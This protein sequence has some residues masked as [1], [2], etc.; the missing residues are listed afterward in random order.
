MIT[1]IVRMRFAP[2]DHA[3]IETIL[4]ELTT[5]SRME[6]GCV[7]YV[8]HFVEG[9]G[10]AVLIYEQ[11]MDESALEAHRNSPHFERLAVGVLYQKMKERDI[12]T[13]A[14]IA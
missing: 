12:E 1:F 9:D 4:R 13:L 8:P 2:E 7:S 5:A 14:A 6:P 3:E 11:Y 10:E